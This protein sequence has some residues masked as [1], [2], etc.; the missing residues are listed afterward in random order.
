M[1]KKILDRNP[2]AI[3]SALG[4]V[5]VLLFA[6]CFPAEAQQ[7]NKVYRIG[8]LSTH[9]TEAQVHQLA[10]F[11][12]GMRELGYVEGQNYVIEW[13]NAKG[14]RDRVPEVA[15]ELVR[16]NVDII[17]TSPGR[18]PMSAAHEATRTIPIVMS[19][20]SRDPVQAGYVVSLA[21]PGGNMTGLADL[22]A[23]VHGKRLEILKEAFPGISR[24][25]VLWHRRQLERWGKKIEAEGQALGILI[26]SVR[27]RRRNID[28]TFSEISRN[29][30]GLLVTAAGGATVN[31][32]E[33]IVNFAAQKR[34]LAIYQDSRFVSDGGLM[35]YGTDM[36]DLFRRA[37]TYVDKILKGAKP[38][39]LPVERPTKFDL[40][41]N[42][43]T[44]KQLGVT[45]PP[46][47]LLQANKVIK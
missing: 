4:L 19:G 30:E 35:S 28:K 21:R 16:L 34:L 13:H 9:W 2:R 31:N 11:K 37:A 47:L 6:F 22:R 20:S 10:A 5:W 3:F 46:T 41:I 7:G 33:R 36:T 43:K 27:A 25:T 12:Q 42:L 15:A 45:I 29:T 32:R 1:R 24:V 23:E 39:D 26:Q 38:A 17:L 8:Y 40:V 44:A 14:K 18:P